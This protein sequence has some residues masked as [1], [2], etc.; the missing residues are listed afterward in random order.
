MLTPCRDAEKY[1][2]ALSLAPLAQSKDSTDCLNEGC[3]KRLQENDLHTVY[4]GQC[5]GRLHWTRGVHNVT[6]MRGKK[7]LLTL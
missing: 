5:I 1:C 4:R 6:F 2:P 7:F 3:L